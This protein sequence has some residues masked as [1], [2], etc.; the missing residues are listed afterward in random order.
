MDLRQSLWRNMFFKGHNGYTLLEIMLALALFGVLSGGVFGIVQSTLE[1]ITTVKALSRSQAEA[2]G[3]DVVLREIC[4]QLPITAAVY[5]EKKG[6]SSQ[7]MEIQFLRAP[8]ALQWGQ[9]WKDPQE[10]TVSLAAR[11]QTEGGWELSARKFIPTS[12]KDLK[13]DLLPWFPLAQGFS[14]IVWSFQD[15]LSGEWKDQW[16]NPL[17]RPLALGLSLKR[18]GDIAPRRT[19]FYIPQVQSNSV[20]HFLGPP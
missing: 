12:G 8:G 13:Q 16:Q 4:A 17:T 10:V 1:S 2:D 19:I 6:D 18:P 3:L 7:S 5:V 15:P 11:P 9:R 14:E 20:P